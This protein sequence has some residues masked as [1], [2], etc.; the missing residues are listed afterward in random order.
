MDNMDA[1]VDIL[2]EMLSTGTKR[3]IV[4]GVLISFALFF[5]GLAIT[6]MTMKGVN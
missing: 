1:L 3:H 2:D 5:G 6:A 4:A